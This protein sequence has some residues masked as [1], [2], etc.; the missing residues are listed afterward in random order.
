LSF[1]NRWFLR[2][3]FFF[4]FLAA[5]KS[6]PPFGRHRRVSVLF[7]FHS[8]PRPGEDVFSFFLE[9]FFSK[10]LHLFGSPNFFPPFLLV[11]CQSF[12]FLGVPLDTGGEGHFVYFFFFLFHGSSL[13]ATPLR[14]RFVIF[15]Q[16]LFLVEPFF[17]SWNESFVVS[18]TLQ[19]PVAPAPACFFPLL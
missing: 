14:L 9:G 16:P 8:S 19:W 2:Q 4:C 7:D 3:L 1:R 10:P 12:V 5:P 6:A 11:S 17:L 18:R 15:P 13:H